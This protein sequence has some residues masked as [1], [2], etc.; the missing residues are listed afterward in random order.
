MP[1][2]HDQALRDDQARQLPLGERLPAQCLQAVEEDGPLCRQG[3]PDEGGHPPVQG[4]APQA[5]EVGAGAG[6]HPLTSPHGPQLRGHRREESRGH[7]RLPC[8]EIE[9][10]DLH[11]A[12]VRPHG[13]PHLLRGDRVSR[14]P[15]R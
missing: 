9:R 12:Q 10:G 11:A 14:R 7:A 8:G 15:I 13:R 2:E 3:A 6:Q 1:G 4:V 5:G